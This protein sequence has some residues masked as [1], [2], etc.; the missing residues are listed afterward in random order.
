MLVKIGGFF[1]DL[2]LIVFRVMSTIESPESLSEDAV[3]VLGFLDIAVF[4]HDH[5]VGL[6]QVFFESGGLA[7][8]TRD[9]ARMVLRQHGGNRIPFGGKFENREVVVVLP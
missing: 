3:E 6:D 8:K 9:H 4:A 2:V 5:R 7:E 1:V